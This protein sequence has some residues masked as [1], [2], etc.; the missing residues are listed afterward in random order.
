MNS[1]DRVLKTI[2]FDSPDRYPIMHAILPGA[3]LKYRD[4]LYNILKKYPVY[5]KEEFK[6]EEIKKWF[7]VPGAYSLSEEIKERYVLVN[8][9]MWANIRTFQYGGTCQK[10]Y[11]SDEWGCVWQKK[12]PG[13]AGI[14]VKNPLAN[15]AEEDVED[16]LENNINNYKFPDPNAYWRYD[17]P[18][19]N[20][21]SKF[22]KK[23]NK[24]FLAH[25]GNIFEQLQRLFSYEDLMIALKKNP[26]VI[27]K[28]ISKIV[29][30]NI[31]TIKNISKYGVDCVTMGDDWGTQ[32]SLMINPDMWRK[33]FKSAYKKIIDEAKKLNLHFLFHTDGN[34]IEIIKDLIEIGV[35]VINPQLSA[36]DME[37]LSSICRGR[38]C[39]LTDIDRQYILNRA[40][41]EEVRS[42]VKKVIRLL[43]TKKGGLIL[44]GEIGSDTKLENIEEMYKCFEE[45]GLIN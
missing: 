2:K 8:D 34:T 25:I 15:F 32:V 43:G 7:T 12:D 9:F 4:K 17:I 35:D 16:V 36:I 22:A 1:K 31:E 42:Y 39:I 6:D 28:F 11:Q 3:W 20:S 13:I 37:K 23:A 44:R 45:F 40:T 27:Q 5:L 26:K 24:Y 38:V 18:F 14:V 21:Q 10:G 19:L 41:I 29:N 33:Y 30:Y